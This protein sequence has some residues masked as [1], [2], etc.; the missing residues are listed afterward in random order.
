MTSS[1]GVLSSLRIV[2]ILR[3]TRL[4]RDSG[5][6]GG[7]MKFL[8]ALRTLIHSR[9]EEGLKEVGSILKA[10]EMA[11]KSMVFM[12]FPGFKAILVIF[13]GIIRAFDAFEGDL[14]GFWESLP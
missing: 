5:G 4:I 2:R 13:R 9:L 3:V 6:G 14:K 12:C 7:A 10:L 11:S 8:R 1:L